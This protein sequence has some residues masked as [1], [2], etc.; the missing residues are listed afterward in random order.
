MG[1]LDAAIA[2]SKMVAEMLLARGDIISDL[3]M[4]LTHA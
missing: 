1:E 4:T 2:L 3:I